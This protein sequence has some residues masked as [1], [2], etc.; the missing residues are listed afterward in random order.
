MTSDSERWGP[1]PL[2]L[3]GAVVG[4]CVTFLVSPHWGGFTL[5]ATLMLAAALRFSGY[6]GVMAIRSKKTDVATMGGFGFVIV[7]TSLLLDNEDLKKLILS[8]LAQ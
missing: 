7:L 1:Y 4:V 3:V 8:L 2:I 6:A 5:G